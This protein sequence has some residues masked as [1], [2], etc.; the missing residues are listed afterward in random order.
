[1]IC[2]FL[3]ETN[4]ESMKGHNSRKYEEMDLKEHILLNC[5]FTAYF[6]NKNLKT[7]LFS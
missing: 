5:E 4:Y 3:F 1:M 6:V 7:E 2:F